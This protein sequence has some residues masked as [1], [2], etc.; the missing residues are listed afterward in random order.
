MFKPIKQ[1]RIYEEILEQIKKLISEGVL[2]PGDRLFAERE[3]AEKLQVSRA[4]IREAFSVLD[5]LGILETKPGEG[6]FI[7]EISHDNGIKPLAL[8]FMLYNNSKLDVM[9]VRMILEVESAALAAQRATADDLKKIKEQLEQMEQDVLSG[10]IG[11]VP[12]ARFHHAV[13]EAANN[14]VLVRLMHTVYDLIV[15]TMRYSRQRLFLKPG[16]KEKL[17]Q[18][19][20]QIFNAILAGNP[21]YARDAMKEHLTFVIEEVSSFEEERI[22]NEQEFAAVE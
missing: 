21:D 17:L 14:R 8:V 19:H 5:L 10:Q 1:K 13:A 9:E 12:D 18:Q 20:K 16:N 15:E 11:E 6:T 3:L 22:D 4:S 2:K 7:R